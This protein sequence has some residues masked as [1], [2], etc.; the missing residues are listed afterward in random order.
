VSEIKFSSRILRRFAETIALEL[1]ADQFS[2]MLSL[3]NLPAEWKTPDVF[4][5]LNPYDSAHVY[6]AL[7]TA[8][9]TY[10]G[11]GARGVLLR[12][13]QRLWH[14]LLDDATFGIKA[15]AAVVKRLPLA[16]RRKPTLELLAKFMGA[17][18]GDIA[19]HTLDMDLLFVDNASPSTHDQS[20]PSPI[21]FV[22]QGLIRECLFWA[23]GKNYDVDE[24]HC[25]AH[26]EHACEFKITGG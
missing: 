14:D 12:V 16:S 3:A 21:C 1:G 25:K 18:S 11:R 17:Q 5:K 19:V 22:T 20:E 9:R 13:G 2:A 15:Q 24:I 23:T 7:Q 26:G 8:M 4:L 10:F 6:A